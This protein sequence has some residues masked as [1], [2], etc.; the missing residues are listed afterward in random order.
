MF[1]IWSLLIF[2]DK[3]NYKDEKSIIILL[4]NF[5]NKVCS[6]IYKKKI[7]PHY[8]LI[9]RWKSWAPDTLYIEVFVVKLLVILLKD[10]S[11]VGYKLCSD[12]NILIHSYYDLNILEH[13]FT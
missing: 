6:T 5:P 7:L 4:F 1:S 9:N 10:F 11:A 2:F 12:E 3:F 13:D 8:C